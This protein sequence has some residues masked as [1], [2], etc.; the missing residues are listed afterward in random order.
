[1]ASY[2]AAHDDPCLLWKN[3][4]A[5]PELSLVSHPLWND[6]KSE[7]DLINT[8]VRE[9]EQIPAGS[10]IWRR[11]TSGCCYSRQQF[12]FLQWTVE[13]DSRWETTGRHATDRLESLWVKSCCLCYRSLATKTCEWHVM[14]SYRTLCLTFGG[15][16]E[17]LWGFLWCKQP[18][19]KQRIFDL[20]SGTFS[21]YLIDR[22]VRRLEDR[23]P[24]LVM[25]LE[26]FQSR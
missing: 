7:S 18:G 19:C 8:I 20:L 3:L 24:S 1:M 26:F 9:W 10:K 21:E 4:T 13:N 2:A 6:V 22:D 16:L 11:E 14:S 15:G 23:S 25:F 5:H 17:P 12:V